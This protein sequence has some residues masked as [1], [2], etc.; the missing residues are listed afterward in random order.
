MALGPRCAGPQTPSCACAHRTQTC[1]GRS[2]CPSSAARRQPWQGWSR[3]RPTA[4]GTRNNDPARCARRAPASRVTTSRTS[5]WPTS[6]ELEPNQ[7]RLKHDD[8]QAREVL[9][10]KYKPKSTPERVIDIHKTT[11]TIAR[12]SALPNITNSSYACNTLIES[13]PI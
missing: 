10:I 7:R 2:R 11:Q 6:Q 1:A 8:E 13:R 5:S 12:C 9:Y 4:M 3:R